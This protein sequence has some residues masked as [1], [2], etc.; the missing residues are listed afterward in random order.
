[1]LGFSPLASAPLADDGGAQN[2]AS[3]TVIGVAGSA[4]VASVTSTQRKPTGNVSRALLR[5]IPT[6]R[7]G[8]L[9]GLLT[10]W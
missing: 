5:V 9:S 10:T 2:N 7:L 8:L 1:M 6:I 3:F 4:A